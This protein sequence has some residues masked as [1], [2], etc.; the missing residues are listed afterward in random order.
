MI[1]NKQSN[2]CFFCPPKNGTY[3]LFKFLT[4]LK[5]N[6]IDAYQHKLPEELIATYP[7]L[8]NYKYFVFARNPVDR[9]CSFVRFIKKTDRENFEKVLLQ[10]G[11]NKT[12]EEF[13]YDDV[14]DHFDLFINQWKILP[15]PQHKWMQQPNTEILDFDNFE[16]ETRRISGAVDFATHPMP[17]LNSTEDY[18]NNMVSD[19]VASFIRTYY[20][21]DYALIK[22]RLGKE[23][24]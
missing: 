22:D 2:L 13:S 1:F 6:A 19:K 8:V 15:M 14:V 18:G 12:V 23:Y 4:D 16:A 3:T 17:W 20:V 7:N 24:V 21:A 9:F 5:W 11:V 10:T